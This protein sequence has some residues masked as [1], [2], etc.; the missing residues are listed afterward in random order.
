MRV[1][2][3]REIGAQVWVGDGYSVEYMAIL[4]LMECSE[5]QCDPWGPSI[6]HW[7][8]TSSIAISQRFVESESFRPGSWVGRC[9][10]PG[11]LT[12]D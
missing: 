2:A 7:F 5:W 9:S 3:C 4:A 12:S 10:L 6:S 1:G 11:F 8:N